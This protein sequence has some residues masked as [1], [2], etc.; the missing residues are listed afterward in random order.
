MTHAKVKTSMCREPKHSSS[1]VCASNLAPPGVCISSMCRKPKHSSSQV[2]ASNL[3]PRASASR[4]LT[5]YAHHVVIHHTPLLR[6]EHTASCGCAR[7][8]TG[9]L[10]NVYGAAAP[11]GLRRPIIIPLSSVQ[12][13]IAGPICSVWRGGTSGATTPAFARV[14]RRRRARPPRP[15]HRPKTSA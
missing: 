10:S 12:K 5:G 2:S 15:T 14:E 9:S 8:T 13:P 1:Q 6:R 3:A 7:S 11:A 4:R